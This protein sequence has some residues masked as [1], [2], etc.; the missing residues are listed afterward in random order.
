MNPNDKAFPTQEFYDEKLVGVKDGLSVRDYIA[1]EAMVALIHR[2][3]KDPAKYAEVA[4]ELGTTITA[5]VA[6]V[7]YVYADAL[8]AES[9]KK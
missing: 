9:N 6:A 3:N 8:V 4:S 7:A 2:V 1:I 5:K